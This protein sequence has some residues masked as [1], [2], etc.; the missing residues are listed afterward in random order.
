MG[1]DIVDQSTSLDT[2]DDDSDTVDDDSD[3]VDDGSDTVDDDSDTVDDDSDTVDDDSDTVD[4]DSDTVDDGSDTVDDDS[5]TVDDGSDTVD[6]D[7][8]DEPVDSAQF[9]E[10]NFTK[11]G[12]NV[13]VY[14]DDDFYIGQVV[15]IESPQVGDVK[16][17]DKCGLE[18]NV[19][20]W[21]RSDVTENIA[22]MF[23]FSWDF[24]LSTS[25][26]RMWQLGE[27]TS[28]SKKYE[29]YKELFC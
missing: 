11:Q 2:V 15:S 12:Q 8:E 20:K 16:F 23:V 5:D 19:Y 25:N 18:T 14:F 29:L 22:S 13:A 17:M 27:Y 7:T 28:V 1:S 4:D 3:T 26:G 24:E 10:F 6:G 21:P 9:G